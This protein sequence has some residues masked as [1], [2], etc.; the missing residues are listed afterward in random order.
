MVKDIFSGGYASELDPFRVLV[1]LASGP[2]MRTSL[3]AERYIVEFSPEEYRR[4]SCKQTSAFSVE[5][6]TNED[7]YLLTRPLEM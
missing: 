6:L 3:R 2:K 4:G 7:H 5:D 1:K